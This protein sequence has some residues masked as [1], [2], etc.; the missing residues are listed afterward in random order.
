MPHKIPRFASYGDEMEQFIIVYQLIGVGAGKIDR[1]YHVDPA[2]SRI[3]EYTASLIHHV[4]YHVGGSAVDGVNGIDLLII[5]AKKLV[6]D[7]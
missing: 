4:H 3:I 5:P 7:V 6:S 2:M 1:S